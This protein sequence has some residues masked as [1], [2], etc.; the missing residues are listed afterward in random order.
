MIAYPQ[1]EF[2]APSLGLAPRS[3]PSL[4]GRIL[5]TVTAVRLD[6]LNATVRGWTGAIL[7]GPVAAAAP[8]ARAPGQ[9]FKIRISLYHT[10]AR[11]S[12]PDGSTGET[13]SSG[14]VGLKDPGRGQKWTGAGER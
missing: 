11:V 5:A 7:H 12:K 14:L 2:S 8:S 4:A 13:F 3:P 9:R 6:T 10:L 1:F